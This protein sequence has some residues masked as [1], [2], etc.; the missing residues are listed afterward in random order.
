MHLCSPTIS[1]KLKMCFG[2]QSN[3]NLLAECLSKKQNFN[4]QILN[5]HG[6]TV[7]I[8]L[9]CASDLVVF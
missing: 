4:L 9:V 7:L 3:E 8:V 5:K 1:A 2:V 6:F